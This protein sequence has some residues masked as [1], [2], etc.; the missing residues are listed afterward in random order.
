M[1]YASYEMFMFQ[2][3][4]LH[5]CSHAAN[6]AN[7]AASERQISPVCLLMYQEKYNPP[8]DGSVS[9][10]CCI[11]VGNLSIDRSS[12]GPPRRPGSLRSLFPMRRSRSSPVRGGGG[13]VGGG[14]GTG[15][16]NSP[17]RLRCGVNR[18]LVTLSLGGRAG[19]PKHAT[20][21]L[22]LP[23]P[24]PPPPLLPPLRPSDDCAE[25]TPWVLASPSC[26][27]VASAE[28]DASPS[29]TSFD[30]MPSWVDTSL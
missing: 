22:P 13:G 18:K 1:I 9:D 4:S 24:S 5:K 21:P 7:D 19:D 28:E 2:T 11:L 14:G 23:L 27:A 20:P 12:V 8:A 30:A 29:A 17:L 25:A 10:A 3:R 6:S 16:A 26:S 15:E